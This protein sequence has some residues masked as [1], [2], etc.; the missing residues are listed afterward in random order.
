MPFFEY[1]KTLQSPASATV[2][3][4]QSE[5]ELVNIYDYEF[6]SRNTHNTKGRGAIEEDM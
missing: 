1:P 5:A 4:L 6:A 2:A 3:L